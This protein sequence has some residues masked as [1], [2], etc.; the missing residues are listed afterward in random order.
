MEKN[1]NPTV[2]ISFVIIERP[3]AAEVTYCVCELLC[4]N[5]SLGAA[6]LQWS[7]GLFPVKTKKLSPNYMPA[8]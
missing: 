4:S 5:A 8:H 1:N 6:W 3:L 7:I 2:H